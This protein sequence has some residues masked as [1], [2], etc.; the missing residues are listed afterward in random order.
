[1]ML[2]FVA[3]IQAW[4]YRITENAR[5]DDLR[6]TLHGDSPRI[7][8]SEDFSGDNPFSAGVI[9]NGWLRVDGQRNSYTLQ[10][11]TVPYANPRGTTATTDKSV[12]IREGKK[13]IAQ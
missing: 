3:G 13:H 12:I 9:D 10:G 2:V 11:Y 4:G 1:M 6:I 5:F 8:F 7:V